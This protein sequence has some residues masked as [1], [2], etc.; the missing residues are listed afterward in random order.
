MGLSVKVEGGHPLN[1]RRKREK[2]RRMKIL[3]VGWG[4]SLLPSLS[5]YQTQAL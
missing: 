5:S 1:L 2:G 4:N 3:D